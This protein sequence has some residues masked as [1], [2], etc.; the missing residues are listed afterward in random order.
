MVLSGKDLMAQ[1]FRLDL[2]LP[3]LFQEVVGRETG[4]YG[5]ITELMTFSMICSVVTFSASAS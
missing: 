2:D 4:H 5:T 1:G 3:D